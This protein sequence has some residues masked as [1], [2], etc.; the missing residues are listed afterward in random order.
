MPVAI[1][2]VLVAFQFVESVVALVV[3]GQVVAA[4]FDHDVVA[5]E[6]VAEFSEFFAGRR[7]APGGERGADRALAAA[8]QYHPV[9]AVVSGEL[10]H[11]VDGAALLAPGKLGDADG[12]AQPPVPVRIPGEHEQVLVC[13]VW[14]SGPV[15]GA[16]KTPAW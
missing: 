6:G 3:L 1:A 8:G 9:A 4:Q 11:V 2:V 10:L 12:P 16:D 14:D 15:T 13:G 5:A 7:G